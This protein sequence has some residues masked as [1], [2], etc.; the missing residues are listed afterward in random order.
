MFPWLLSCTHQPTCTAWHTRSAGFPVS[1]LSSKRLTDIHP[2]AEK[3]LFVAPVLFF[4]LADKLVCFFLGQSCGLYARTLV[5]NT[6]AVIILPDNLPEFAFY[7][8]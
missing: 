5:N 3:E 1:H 2:H 7:F 6:V 4:K 8:A